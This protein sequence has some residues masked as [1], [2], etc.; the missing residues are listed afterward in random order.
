MSCF[1]SGC[2]QAYGS[3]SDE[4]DRDYW[5]GRPDVRRLPN[6]DWVQGRLA[7]S[8]D[9]GGGYHVLWRAWEMAAC[10]NGEMFVRAWADPSVDRDT[11][12]RMLG[13][14]PGKADVGDWQALFG[15]S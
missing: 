13:S 6:G 1:R 4:A 5:E 7:K 3:G 12:E 11:L 8:Q 9:Q 15:A 10:V 14:I 2:R